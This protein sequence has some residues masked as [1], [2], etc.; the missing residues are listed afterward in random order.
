MKFIKIVK[1]SVRYVLSR[2]IPSRYS[3]QNFPWAFCLPTSE[4]IKNERNEKD[5]RDAPVRFVKTRCQSPLLPPPWPTELFVRLYFP[6]KPEKTTELPPDRF[7]IP[8]CPS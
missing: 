8:T 5:G 1:M 3:G 2:L 4:P 7:G 6:I